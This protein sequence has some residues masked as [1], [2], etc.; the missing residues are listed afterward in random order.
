[1]QIN[2]NDTTETQTDTTSSRQQQ[3]QSKDHQLR[4][5]SSRCHSHQHPQKQHRRHRNRHHRSVTNIITIILTY[6]YHNRR[7]DQHMHKQGRRQ[8]LMSIFG[9][10]KFNQRSHGGC[11]TNPLRQYAG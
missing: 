2:D 10:R 4:M 7:S 5:M 8:R 1:M 3:L 9:F 11:V 6:C